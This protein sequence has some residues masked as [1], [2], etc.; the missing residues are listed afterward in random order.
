MRPSE[1]SLVT[2]WIKVILK[3]HD[4]AMERFEWVV[5]EPKG[6]LAVLERIEVSLYAGRSHTVSQKDQMIH[7][8]ASEDSRGSQNWWG[9]SEYTLHCHNVTSREP[10]RSLVALRYVLVPQKDREYLENRLIV[11]SSLKGP[12][13]YLRTLILF[14]AF[15]EMK[16][17]NEIPPQILQEM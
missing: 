7:K 16:W 10:Y 14:E 13:D 2:N 17:N 6:T 9:W 4:K 11:K 15:K 12:V 8:R 5:E 3:E 1:P